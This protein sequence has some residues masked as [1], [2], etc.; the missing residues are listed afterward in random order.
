MT[1]YCRLFDN[2]LYKATFEEL[3][4]M[5]LPSAD[6]CHQ[7]RQHVPMIWDSMPTW[8]ASRLASGSLA[9]TC[10]P[11]PS[12]RSFS[13]TMTNP[14]QRTTCDVRPVILASPS[15]KPCCSISTI[16][17]AG[18]D[19]L[20]PTMTHCVVNFAFVLATTVNSQSS[21]QPLPDLSQFA[22]IL[23]DNAAATVH[24]V[25]PISGRSPGGFAGNR[26]MASG[27]DRS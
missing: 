18:C 15:Q 24:L 1:E 4:E 20:R 8:I 23:N 16:R 26:H 7:Q 6:I 10:S 22:P 3:L 9:G 5:E 21:F 27:N 11:P 19:S 12:A 17:P 13:S 25:R 14:T 2:V